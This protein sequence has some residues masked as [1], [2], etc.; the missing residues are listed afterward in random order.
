MSKSTYVVDIIE[1]KL[2]SLYKIHMNLRISIV[3]QVDNMSRYINY[4]GSY[5]VGDSISSVVE[6]RLK[7]K[8][9]SAR[10]LLLPL[11]QYTCN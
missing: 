3:N 1:S 6:A 10:G 8:E 4:R 2:L 9:Q 5:I 7:H 11:N